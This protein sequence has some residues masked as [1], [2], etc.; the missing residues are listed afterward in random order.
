MVKQKK[1]LTKQEE[2]EIMKIVLDKFLLL[3]VFIMS[4]GIYLIVT[5]LENFAMGFT[6][7]GVG[8]VILI[9]FAMILVKEYNFIQH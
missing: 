2:F 3:G 4:L 1:H 7:L 5:A 6:V 8:A 9:I